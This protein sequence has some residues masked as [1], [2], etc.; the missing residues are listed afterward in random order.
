MPAP[1]EATMFAIVPSRPEVGDMNDKVWTHLSVVPWVSLGDFRHEA[2]QEIEGVVKQ[3]MPVHLEPG[4]MMTVGGEG[5]EKKAQDITS[6]ELREL[7]K[8]L[9]TTLG[10]FGVVV[11]HPEWAWNNYRPH[12]THPKPM[13]LRPAEENSLYV[14]DNLAIGGDARGTKLISQCF[15]GE[16]EPDET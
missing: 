2:L 3:S 7:H 4:R 16:R 10:G 14:I 12:I 9:L 13:L 8:K 1:L 5:H 15:H 11:S 6:E